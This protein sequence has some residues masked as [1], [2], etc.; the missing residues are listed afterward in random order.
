[1]KHTNAVICFALLWLY[2]LSYC[3][4][5]VINLQFHAIAES[6]SV[7]FATKV[8]YM[9]VLIVGKE[10]NH[11]AKQILHLVCPTCAEYATS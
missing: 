10:R 5:H 6:V 11:A 2:I 9:C 3:C 8:I 1:M 4:I 7:Y